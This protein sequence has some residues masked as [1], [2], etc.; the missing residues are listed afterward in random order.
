MQMRWLQH[1]A[2]VE[3]GKTKSVVN[4]GKPILQYRETKACK[5]KDVETIDNFIEVKNV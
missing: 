2:K 3:D 1:K 4:I 5:W